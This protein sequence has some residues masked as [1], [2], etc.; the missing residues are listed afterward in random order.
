MAD[1]TAP[2][3]YDAVQP[4]AHNTDA[5]PKGQSKQ[6]SK[7]VSWVLGKTRT[8]EDYRD[9]NFKDKW[10]E[11]YRLWRGIW[12][13]D[14]KTRASERSKLISP[15]IQQAVE[16]TVAE[17]EE[18]IFGKGVWFD[19]EDDVLDEE[20]GDM[21]ILRDRLR[22]DL[23]NAKVPTE[24]AVVF[25]NGALY[26]TGIAKMRVEEVFEK[27]IVAKSVAG[28]L[29]QEPGVEEVP[30]FR[31]FLDA[32]DPREFA[33][34]PAARSI[35]DAL[36]CAHIVVKPEHTILKKQDDGVYNDYSLG[37]YVDDTDIS[38][39][40][41]LKSSMTDG[42]VKIV[43][44]HGLVPR[45][46]LPVELEEDEVLVDLEDDDEEEVNAQRLGQ[47]ETTVD[48]DE[49]DLVEA[50]VTIANDRVLL[51]AT[52][53]A[54]LM[55]D[56]PF[57]FYQHDTVPHRFWGRG[58]VEKG[59]NPQKALDAEL[60][61]RI[62]A[63]A[64]TTHPMM[65][66]D[67]T[68]IPRGQKMSVHPGKVFLT[69]GDPSSILQP[70]NFGQ[71]V[72]PATFHQSGELERMIQM[73]T[74]AMDSAT[75]VG[76]SPRNGT[77]S[78]MSMM[79]SGA[80]KRSKRTLQNIDRNFLQPLVKKASWRYMQFNPERY[81]ITDYKFKVVAGMGMMAREYEQ[82]Q[83]T[84]L[85]SVVPPDSPAFSVLL[86]GIFDNSSLSNKSELVKAVDQMMQGPSPEEQQ[87][88]QQAQQ[89]EM[90][91]VVG[92]VEEIES[93]TLFNV[94]RAREAMAKIGAEDERIDIERAK[95]MIAA[96][97]ANSKKEKTA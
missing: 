63:L 74:G 93:K 56:R 46:L 89:L 1:Y 97:T 67:A 72:N 68:R 26:G 73:G 19:V 70:F 79:M 21:S 81:P 59:Y 62:D 22:E 44:Y 91:K 75:P 58:V 45:E 50:V 47:E 83:L 15:A 66:V 42:M 17:L 77:A 34:D 18:A 40:G 24:V 96:S 12:A 90:R 61:A 51:R 27:K 84:Q 55:Q 5:Q 7:L 64:L 11:Y 65:A 71:G 37:T 87:M 80:M 86:K 49:T 13:E 14:D 28:G 30:T 8:W 52:E 41:E 53:N 76:V 9:T 57:L 4:D 3:K 85:L 36:G 54:L 6:E 43:E 39:R 25:L 82:G 48:V 20:K 16:A 78:G 60:R 38:G 10:D 92:E 31:V 2:G 33:I 23:D 88:Q 69:N 35:D 32:V 95:T 94:A 29:A